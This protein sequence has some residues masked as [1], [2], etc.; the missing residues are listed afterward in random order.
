MTNEHKAKY[1]RAPK[2]T[3]N[4]DDFRV[5]MAGVICAIILLVGSLAFQRLDEY[6]WF[7]DVTLLTPFH[8]VTVDYS[9]VDGKVLTVG[10]Q[11]IKRRC[12]FE[13]MIAYVTGED[14]TRRR[15]IVDP[16]PEIRLTGTDKTRPP[17]S[18]SEAWGPWEIYNQYTDLTP[19][20]WEIYIDHVRCPS[21]PE[22]QTN[23]FAYGPWKAAGFKTHPRVIDGKNQDDKSFDPR[24]SNPR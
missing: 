15:L 23:L 18:E 13:D 24:L 11:L 2:S 1:F 5:L 20:S 10:G 9:F 7:R 8:D 6:R 19:V 22:N 16:S 21:P 12:D 17:S 14:G 3:P 4:R